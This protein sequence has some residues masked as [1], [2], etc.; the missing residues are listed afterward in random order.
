MIHTTFLYLLNIYDEFLILPK[1]FY[2][3]RSNSL[4]LYTNFRMLA[5]EMDRIIP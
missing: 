4:L 1:L 3:K 2:N 5:N